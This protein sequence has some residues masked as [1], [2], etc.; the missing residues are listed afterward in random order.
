VTGYPPERKSR[1]TVRGSGGRRH[2]HHPIKR[3]LII[4]QIALAS[5]FNFISR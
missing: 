1:Q 2:T 3:G 4:P 5:A